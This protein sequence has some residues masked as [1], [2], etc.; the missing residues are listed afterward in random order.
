[1]LISFSPILRVLQSHVACTIMSAG[2]YWRDINL[3]REHLFFYFFIFW[4][5]LRG[6]A[7]LRKISL[8]RLTLLSYDYYYLLSIMISVHVQVLFV[9]VNVGAPVWWLMC[10][11]QMRTFRNWFSPSTFLWVSG[12]ELKLSSLNSKYGHLLSHL[13]DSLL[14]FWDPSWIVG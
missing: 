10:G 11:S 3:V 4:S 1:M 6:W 7:S 13:T 2:R 14:N 9:C 12:I 5:L 8:Q